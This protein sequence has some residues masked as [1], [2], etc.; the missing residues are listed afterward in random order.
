MTAFGLT[1]VGRRKFDALET[2]ALWGIDIA[3]VEE[4]AFAKIGTPFG[5]TLVRFDPISPTVIRSREAGYHAEAPKVVDFYVPDFDKA[6]AAIEQAGWPLKDVVAEYDMPEGHFTEGHVWGPDE[7]VFAL[8]G[9]PKSFFSKMATVTDEMFS[10]P[11]SMSGPI[12]DHG[13]AIAFFERVFDL[14]VVYK[15]GIGDDSFRDLVGSAA[16]S[17]NLTAINIG[18]TSDE[19]YFG[20]I[21]Y[22]MPR[23]SY[24]S[25]YD[26][27]VPPNRGILGATLIVE[28]ADVAANRA[29]EFGYRVLAS[30]QDAVLPGLG[31]VRTTLIKGA[32]GGCYRAIARKN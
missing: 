8:L 2:K 28:N 13:P 29:L 21:H 7:V 17:F 27:C 26:V 23:G 19:P 12:S 5:A 32:N 16:S 9:G 1:E 30:A 22:G 25:L 14:Q 18:L 20:L 15:Y 24:G 6:R 10:E 3:G 11:Q 4:I 31:N